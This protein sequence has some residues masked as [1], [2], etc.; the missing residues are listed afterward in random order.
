MKALRSLIP[1]LLLFLAFTGCYKEPGKLNWKNAPG[2]EQHE[3]LMW[4]A[5]Q[6]QRWDEVEHHLAPTFVGVNSTGQ[7]LDRAGWVEYWKA[8]PPGDFSPGEFSVQP[9]GAD[10]VISYTAHV[11]GAPFNGAGM[12]VL[13]VWQQLKG[14]WVL[15]SQSIT[16]VASN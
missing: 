9:D 16:P 15:I 3:R 1:G 8:H 13:S 5:I 6:G 11:G 7:K 12:Q 2:A 10:M 4:Q 14:G